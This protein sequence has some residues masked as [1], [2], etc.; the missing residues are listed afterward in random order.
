MTPAQEAAIRAADAN[1]KR[2]LDGNSQGNSVAL[3][4]EAHEFLMESLFPDRIK[5][6][7]EGGP[8]I[9]GCWS[10]AKWRVPCGNPNA[11]YPA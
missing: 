3:L 2:I 10:C 5:R 11:C 9:G 6:L 7:D 1:I 8:V 4:L